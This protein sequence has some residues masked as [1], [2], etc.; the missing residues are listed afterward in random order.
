MKKLAQSSSLAVTESPFSIAPRVLCLPP[1]ERQA[2]W[3][4]AWVGQGLTKKGAGEAVCRCQG[5]VHGSATS[6]PPRS[7]LQSWTSYRPP[8]CF[9]PRKGLSIKISGE[10][11]C[12]C[13]APT[14]QPANSFRS[15]PA[16]DATASPDSRS[17]CVRAPPT[18]RC[19]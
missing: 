5:K 13:K 7:V 17:T 19:K 11:G 10:G 15:A 2:G 9:L 12:K 14:A 16:P 3:M 8:P 6:A 1:W 18:S 4:D